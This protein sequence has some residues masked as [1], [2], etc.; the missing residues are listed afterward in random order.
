M[1]GLP[2]GASYLQLSQ[3]MTPAEV[4][5][6]LA[7]IP[8]MP[9]NQALNAFMLRQQQRNALRFLETRIGEINLQD[10][11]PATIAASVFTTALFCLSE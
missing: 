11:L 1:S 2:F 9:L 6:H 4:F 5:P 7:A 3:L 8:D 10:S